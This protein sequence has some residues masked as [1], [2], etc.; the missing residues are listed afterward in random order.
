MGQGISTRP[1]QAL[2]G[3]LLMTA[4]GAQAHFQELIPSTDI[5]TGETGSRIALA[6]KFTHPMER[7]PVMPM[8]MPKRFAVVGPDGEEDLIDQLESEA[9][10]GK[11]AFHA[12]YQVRQPGDYIFYV[13]PAPYWEP[14]EGVMIVHYTKVVV[15]AFGAEQGWDRELGLPVEILPLTRPYGLWSGNLFRGIVKQNGEPV[16]FAEVE[17]EWRNDG[18]ITPPSDPYITQVVKADANGVFSYAMP[19]SGW[20]G[21]AALLEGDAPMESPAGEPVPV[22]AG[23][24]MWVHVRDMR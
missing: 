18:S 12:E 8:G 21:F 17:V 11:E 22:E 1:H 4:L 23:A 3:I 15:D 2:L 14:A 20:W 19:H 6:L 13:E 10:D 16:A 7:G 9:I 5:L 24:L